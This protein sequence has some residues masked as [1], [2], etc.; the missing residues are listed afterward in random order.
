MTKKVQGGYCSCRNPHTFL[1]LVPFVSGR[2]CHLNS[3][4]RFMLT[5]KTSDTAEKLCESGCPVVGRRS[6]ELLPLASKMK[7][8]DHAVTQDLGAYR[9]VICMTR[10]THHEYPKLETGT[11]RVIMEMVKE[12]PNYTQVCGFQ[13]IC[14][15]SGMKKI[16]RRCGL[17]GHLSCDYRTPR[18]TRC[19]G[20]SHASS[21]CWAPCEQCPTSWCSQHICQCADG[22]DAPIRAENGKPQR[23]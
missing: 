8:P 13:G 6:Y 10:E 9:K 3:G 4:G 16:S 18:C 17:G 23:D 1:A 7:A 19:G 14:L 2:A 15:Y 12:V 11:R 5:V 22:R 21:Q 20:Y